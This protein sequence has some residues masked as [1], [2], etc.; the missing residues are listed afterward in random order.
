MATP[1]A[2]YIIL[3]IVR[4]IVSICGDKHVKTIRP[5]YEECNGRSY[6]CQDHVGVHIILTNDDFIEQTCSSAGIG[7]I[8][9]Y[10][11]IRNGHFTQY[12]DD[13]CKHQIDLMRNPPYVHKKECII[14]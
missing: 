13:E 14:F 12:L 10:Y 9:Y 6:P 5:I 4:A 11:G 1:G 2:N 3:E 7:G 8:M